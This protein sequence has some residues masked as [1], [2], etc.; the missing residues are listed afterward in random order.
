[1]GFSGKTVGPCFPAV[2]ASL[3]GLCPLIILFSYD[4]SRMEPILSDAVSLT[5]Y[6]RHCAFVALITCIGVAA[7]MV[8]ID[9]YVYPLPENL[10][11]GVAIGVY[12]AVGGTSARK[13]FR[14]TGRQPTRTERRKLAAVGSGSIMLVSIVV[15]LLS[16]APFYMMAFVF[17][18]P[19]YEIA[20]YVERQKLV[21]MWA[22]LGTGVMLLLLGLA[23]ALTWVLGYFALTL[24]Y[25]STQMYRS[26]VVTTASSSAVT[27]ERTG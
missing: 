5:P 10:G 6:Y 20:Y 4:Q 26:K 1:M 13:F 23:S 2:N 24:S 16:F 21:A 27:E 11:T 7:A 15:A 22:D 25:R 17:D 14:A 12:F 3:A 8:F 19:I 9:L 18:D